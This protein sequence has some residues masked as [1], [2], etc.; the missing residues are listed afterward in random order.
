M[1]ISIAL[2]AIA[3]AVA[4]RA[5]PLRAQTVDAG[6]VIQSGPVSG[7]VVIGEPP[8]VVVYEA[9]VRQVIV[10]ERIHVPHGN[11]YGWWRHHGYR[12]V[13][14]YYDGDSYYARPFEGDVQ[15]HGVVVYEREGR[16]YEE[17]EEH[18]H[19]HGHHGHGRHDRDDDDD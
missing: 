11:A 15:L 18:G 17:W 4:L 14:L 10:V 9:P 19:G 7:H 2:A 8:P 12:P 16:Y 5:A 13:T 3:A 1:R 6:V